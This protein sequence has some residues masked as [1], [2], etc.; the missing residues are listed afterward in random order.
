[1]LLI[2]NLEVE[3][4]A[5]VVH[6]DVKWRAAV[7]IRAGSHLDISISISR[8]KQKQYDADN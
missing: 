3:V 4:L 5:F 6:A 1:M 2:N 7:S 8:H